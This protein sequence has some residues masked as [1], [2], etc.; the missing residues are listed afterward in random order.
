MRFM[1]IVKATPQSEAGIPPNPELIEAIGKEAEKM[2]KAG[3]MIANGG[4]FPSSKGTRIKVSDQKLFVIDGPFAETRELIGGFAIMEA[5]SKEEAIEMGRGFMQLHA[6]ILGPEY[7][8]ELEIRPMMEMDNGGCV[9][10]NATAEA[11]QT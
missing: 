2:A 1:M 7:E 10:E 6:N 3:V 8:G 9:Q 5:K 11:A 4:L